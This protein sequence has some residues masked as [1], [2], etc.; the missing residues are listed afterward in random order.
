[1]NLGVS[2]R[3][4]MLPSELHKS[5][6]YLDREFIADRYEVSV[7]ESPSTTIT[8]NEA[9]KAGVA[10]PIFS[11]EVSAHE[12]RT[13]KISSFEMLVQTW[14]SLEAEENI[15]SK[16][17]TSGMRSKYGWVKGELTVYQA[18]S[19]IQRSNGDNEVTAESEHFQLRESITS[20]FSL[21]TTPEYFFSGLG[22]FVRLQKTVLKEM[23]IPV[24]A[25]VRVM[26][27]YD[28]FSH[29][30]AVPLVVLERNS[31]G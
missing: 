3:N 28:H 12:T 9:K 25:Y 14:D 5:L 15:D 23:S 11:A 2:H 22:T 18:K 29:W 24:A 30:V 8:K 17:F 7:G 19:S 1:M 21:I 6:L 31:D 4:I 20:A 16:C 26:A 10:I 13:Y 27:A